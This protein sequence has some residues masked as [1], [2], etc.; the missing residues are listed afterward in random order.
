[1]FRNSNPWSEDEDTILRK[2]WADGD[3]A[4]KI[5]S[6]LEGRSRN[7][8]LGRCRRLDLVR[9]HSPIGERPPSAP[10]KPRK[11]T[12]EENRDYLEDSKAIDSEWDRAIAEAYVREHVGG[13]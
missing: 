7:A 3:S 6:E 13:W 4:G 1:M 2:M 12:W 10:Y 5:S 8:V 9:R 11:V